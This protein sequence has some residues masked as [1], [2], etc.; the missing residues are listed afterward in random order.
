M[1]KVCFATGKG[2]MGIAF[3]AAM[4]L[5]VGA[6]ANAADLNAEAEVSVEESIGDVSEVSTNELNEEI[7]EMYSDFV[8][9]TK[10]KMNIKFVTESYFEKKY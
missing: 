10:G 1:K 9:S 5:Q 3:G 7:K 2:L 8:E 6:V 4:F